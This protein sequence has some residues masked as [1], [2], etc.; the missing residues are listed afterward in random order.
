MAGR[1]RKIDNP[2]TFQFVVSEELLIRFKSLSRTDDT[3]PADVARYLI[4]NYV[5]EHDTNIDIVKS[6]SAD[7]WIKDINTVEVKRRIESILV[8]H[9]FVLDKLRVNCVADAIIAINSMR[10]KLTAVTRRKTYKI[11]VG[12]N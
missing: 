12:S 1:P 11:N 9:T 7:V 4:E 2:V 5:T 8:G 6:E 10:E 3:T